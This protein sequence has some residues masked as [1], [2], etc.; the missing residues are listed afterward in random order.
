MKPEL[1]ERLFIEDLFSRSVQKENLKNFK[2]T[3]LERLTG[4][5][6]TR[7]YYRIFTNQESFV[8]CI[9]NPTEAGSN[10]FVQIQEFLSKHDVR[11]PKIYDRIVKKGYILEEDLGDTTLL[12][13]ISNVE[14]ENA[15]LEIY[16]EIIDHLLQIHLI[17]SS[18]VK[19]SEKFNLKF[20]QQKFDEEI[21]FTAKF[22]FRYF[23]G[24]DDLDAE[25]RLCKLFQPINKNLAEQKMVLTHR[26]FHSRNIM[27]KNEKFIIIDFQDARMGIPQYDLVSILEDCYYEISSKNKEI[28]V[29]YYYERLGDNIHGQNNFENF[30]RL[31]NDMTLQR[32]FKAVG[33]FSYIHHMRKDVR[34]IKY[35][36]FAM[37]KIRKV[38]IKYP[39]YNELRK[40][41]FGHYYES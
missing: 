17:P 11:V 9:D 24:L 4:D 26:D 22:F 21:E 25:K 36:G 23:L 27:V 37:E 18:E 40:F 13:Y 14:D 35:I 32:V 5:A 7:R 1:S 20:D 10:P 3:N 41:L 34:Y 19:S 39:E 12:N 16:K 31:Y 28:L 30:M 33:S 38:L 8:A 29:N 6:S 15:E 2:L